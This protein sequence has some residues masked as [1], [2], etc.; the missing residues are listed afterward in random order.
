M[1]HP[2]EEYDQ[3]KID[4]GFTQYLILNNYLKE[5]ETPHINCLVIYFDETNV[6]AYAGKLV[7]NG[8]TDGKRRVQGYWKQLKSV[9]EHDLWSVPTSYGDTIKY[10]EPLPPE[11]TME[12]YQTYHAH[13][14]DLLSKTEVRD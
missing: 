14:R 5:L 6:P 12:Y 13:I 1:I 4:Q 2:V 10:Y 7:M 3:E 11:K 9:M 8:E